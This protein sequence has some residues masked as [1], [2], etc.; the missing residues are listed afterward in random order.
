MKCPKCQFNNP[1]G[2]NFCGK[3]G[4]KLERICPSCN[5]ANPPEFRF[6]GKCG[7]QLEESVTRK[8]EPSIEGERKQVTVLFSDLSE[9]TAMSERLDPEEVKNIMSRIF[10][11]VTQVVAKYDGSIEKFIGDAVVAFFGIPKV[12]EDDPVWAIRAAIEIHD[13]VEAISA[14]FQERIGRPLWMHTGIN[15]GLVVTGEVTMEKGPLGVTGDAVN[16]AQR[17]SGLA[18]PGE[19]LVGH[20]TY[21]QAGGYFAFEKMEPTKVK[22]KTEPVPVYRVVEERVKVKRI[23]G[24]ATQGISS[25]LVGRD[26]EFVVIKGCVNRLLDGRG[27]ILSVIGEAGLGKSRLMAEIR[28]RTDFSSLQ[29]L[30]GRTL[31]YSQKISYWPFQEIIRQYAEISEDDSDLEAWQKLESR[32]T[33]LF[34]ADTG[35][36]LPYLAS[37]LTLDIKGEYATQ[38]K[39]LDGE[40]M[41][42]QVFLAS[43]RFF[44][45][46]AQTQP[47]ML[48]FEDLHWADES[49]TLLLEHLLPLVNRAPLLICGVSRPEPK[50]PVFRFREIAGKDFDRRY[51]EIRLGP[52]SQTESAELMRNLLEIENLPARVR[53]LIIHKAEGNPF[54]LEEIMRSLIDRG[55]VVRDP[56]TGR[57]RATAHIEAITIPDTIQG[58]IMARVDRL[59]EELKQVLRTASVIGRSFL[60]RILRAIEQVVHELDRH[61]DN[62]QAMELIREKQRIPELE[63]IFKHALVQ[64][65]TYE[66][67]L[68][69]KRRELHAQVAKAIE[70]LFPDRLEEFYSVLAYHYAQAEAWENAQD[71]LFKA[72]DQAGRIAADN[73]AL[74]HYQQAM[75]AYARAFGDKWDLIQR[76]SLERKIGEAFYRRGEHQ[77]AMEYLQRA[78]TYLGKS[79][80]TS[81]W[82]VRLAI[83]REIFIQI[84][85]RLLPWLFVKKTDT[86]VSQALEEE[87]RICEIMGYINLTTNLEHFLLI[88]LRSLNNWER[89]GLS[90]G[91]AQ[92]LAALTPI[93]DFM[94]CFWLGGYYA[95]RAVSLAEQIQHPGALGLAYHAL[96]NHEIYT[97]RL[98]KATEHSLKAVEAYRK[99]GYWNLHAWGLASWIPVASHLYQGDF[100]K[101]SAYAQDL[102]RFGQDAGDLQIL[103]EGLVGLGNVQIRMGC[104][105]EADANLKRAIEL[106]GLIPDHFFRI[107]AGFGLGRSY[108]FQRDLGQALAVLVETERFR[109]EKN[110]KWRF[111][112]LFNGLAWAYL[113]AAEESDQN[114]RKNWLR[115]AGRSCR[116]ALGQ[117]KKYRI[118]LAEAMRLK[119]TYEWLRHKP[120]SAQ[121]CW[122]KSLGLAEEMGMRYELGMIYLEMGQRLKDHTHLEKAEAIF[123]E[124]GA[125]WDLGQTRKL[126]KLYD[127]L[128]NSMSG[129]AQPA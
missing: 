20:D 72:G 119:G 115:K 71:Y 122:Q 129:M 39:Y 26:A 51:T 63:Y 37:L 42:R 23:R 45:R 13:K 34:A 11:E 82:G 44:E 59:D 103:C 89:E 3:C 94:S 77:Q 43:R 12:H 90:Y 58:V 108:L 24:L 6:C 8:I 31:S 68:L 121:K 73:E 30:E 1:E 41:G 21:R 111:P 19:I 114:E 29:W 48:V 4:G 62:L 98:N 14:R 75:A 64:E 128:P 97:G 86:S 16:V 33:E 7:H 66:S 61:L 93:F 78:L 125:E 100:H 36:I 55:A 79:L 74:V 91:V 35:E 2:I 110:V 105:N 95:H 81:R 117:G 107:H 32:I 49:S 104:F 76:A 56:T 88:V 17:L 118:G 9:Y 106:S 113:L 123:A 99:G 69:Q 60:Y 52:L 50:T 127:A 80:P 28:N 22:G 126:L 87:V 10:E 102:A 112:F 109:V 57:W 65:S 92:T 53:D 47:L 101:A 67:I 15:T 96:A 40:A 5:F 25:P 120:A 83:L 46:L 38:I 18:K 116:E 85:H 27:G 54:F 124:I 70:T 84:G